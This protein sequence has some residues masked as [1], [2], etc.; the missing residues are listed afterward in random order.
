MPETIYESKEYLAKLAKKKSLWYEDVLREVLKAKPQTI[1]EVGCRNGDFANLCF[2]NGLKKIIALDNSNLF[3]KKAGEKNQEIIF[4]KLN[5]NQTHLFKEILKKH[6]P[7]LIVAI[8]SLEHLVKKTAL[9][10]AISELKGITLIVQCPN[11]YSNLI[12]TNYEFKLGFMLV[13]LLRGLTGYFR[14]L[15]YRF[16][17]GFS[18]PKNLREITKLKK[19]LDYKHSDSDAVVLTSSFWF[20]LFFKQNGF[21]LKKFTSFSFPTKRKWLKKSLACLG[22]LPFIKHLGGK[23]I[24]VVEK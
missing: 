16:L 7:D 11:L 2:E 4:K 17:A 18:S 5:L 15:W 12:G 13:K 8:D 19:G 1:L 22:K 14:Y 10:L 20:L 3:L 23:M 9:L 24:F 21:K 6:E